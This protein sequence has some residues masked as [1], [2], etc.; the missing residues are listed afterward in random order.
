[1]SVLRCCWHGFG[2]TGSDGDQCACMYGFGD[3]SSEPWSPQ[4]SHGPCVCAPG[5]QVQ[6]QPV[7]LSGVI[8]V[9]APS[10]R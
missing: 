8:L 1:M 3:S 5:L 4:P 6:D 10:V 9:T 7:F 2:A